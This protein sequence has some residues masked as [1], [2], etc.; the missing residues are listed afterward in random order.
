MAMAFRNV[1]CVS[2]SYRATLCAL[3][4]AVAGQAVKGEP[5]ATDSNVYK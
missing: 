2:H 3:D 1:N 4:R 5:H